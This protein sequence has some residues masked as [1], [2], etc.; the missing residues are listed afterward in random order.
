MHLPFRRLVQKRLARKGLWKIEA[1][2]PRVLLTASV[3]SIS[4]SEA[5]EGNS[6][7]TE[8][9]FTVSRYNDD[10]DY[11]QPE[12]I[13]YFTGLGDDDGSMATPGSVSDPSLGQYDDYVPRSGLAVFEVGETTTLIRIEVHGDELPEADEHFV[14][15]LSPDPYFQTDFS[16]QPIPLNYPHSTAEQITNVSFAPAIKVGL[17]VIL[18]SELDTTSGTPRGIVRVLVNISGDTPSFQ[19]IGVL[20]APSDS[21]EQIVK[22]DSA[23]FDGDGVG[24]VLVANPDGVVI[25]QGLIGQSYSFSAALPLVPVGDLVVTDVVI[26]DINHDGRPDVAIA[27][28]NGKIVFLI[29]SSTENGQ[30]SFANP[31]LLALPTQPVLLRMADLDGNS[32]PDVI[33]VSAPA[34]LGGLTPL[35]I[36]RNIS[37]PGVNDLTFESD[38][39]RVYLNSTWYDSYNVQ[40]NRHIYDIEVSDQ[41]GD[42]RADLV[43]ST[44]DAFGGVYL[45]YET[46]RNDGLQS[47]ALSYVQNRFTYYND[48][49]RG[50]DQT[51]GDANHD[52][53]SDTS[54]VVQSGGGTFLYIRDASSFPSRAMFFLGSLEA[55]AG[56]RVALGDLNLDGA[57][58][59]LVANPEQGLSWLANVSNRTG[60]PGDSQNVGVGTILDD[61]TVDTRP[62]I[63]LSQSRST[64]FT[65]TADNISVIYATLTS[66]Q[67]LSED[68][69]IPILIDPA[70][71]ANDGSTDFADYA[72]SAYQILIPAGYTTGELWLTALPD[73]GGQDDPDE[74]VIIRAESTTSYLVQSTNPLMAIIT[75]PPEIVLLTANNIAQEA[76]PNQFSII[77][78]ASKPVLEDT[79]IEISFV[80]SSSTASLDDLFFVVGQVITIPAGFTTVALTVT[81]IDDAIPESVEHATF[82]VGSVAQ[83]HARTVWNN[84]VTFTF[85][86]NDPPVE[87]PTVPDIRISLSQQTIVAGGNSEQATTKLRAELVS[88]QVLTHDL[89]V[90]ISV[91]A[92]S[93]ASPAAAANPD[94]AASGQVILIAAGNTWGEVT[95]TALSDAA[96]PPEP[97]EAIILRATAT[98]DFSLVTPAPL[99]VTIASIPEIRL[100]L[101][102][103][104]VTEG[105]IDQIQ[106]VAYASRPMIVD[107]DVVVVLISGASTA[108]EADFVAGAGGLIHI[109]AGQTSATFAFTV[110]EDA[111]YEIAETATFGLVSVFQGLA[112]LPSNNLVAATILDND[113]L[114]VVNLRRVLPDGS[115]FTQDVSISETGGTVDVVAVLES[116]QSFSISVPLTSVGSLSRTEYST[117]Y[118][119]QTSTT[120]LPNLIIPAGQLRSPVLRIQSIN[121]VIVETNEVLQ[122]AAVATSAYTVGSRG[123]ISLTVVDDDTP[124]PQ[125]SLQAMSPSIQENGGVSGF[126]VKLNQP[127][128]STVSVNLRFSG[129]ASSSDYSASTTVVIP[130]GETVGVVLVKA[131]DDV[132]RELDETIIA[133]IDSVNG[134]VQSSVAEATMTIRDDDAPVGVSLL[135]ESDVFGERIGEGAISVNLTELTAY[136]VTIRLAFSGSAVL[137]T[138]YTAN[139]AAVTIPAGQGVATLILK[140]IADRFVEGTESVIVLI[141]SIDTAAGGRVVAVPSTFSTAVLELRDDLTP[142][143]TPQLTAKINVDEDQTS[144]VDPTSSAGTFR[145]FDY[146]EQGAAATFTIVSSNPSLIDASGV[147]ISNRVAAS[148]ESNQNNRKFTVTPKPNQ[149]GTATITIRATNRF[150]SAEIS[151]NIIVNPVNDPPTF[152]GGGPDAAFEVGIF[153]DTPVAQNVGT[154]VYDILSGSGNPTR[155]NSLT[156]VDLDPEPNASGIAIVAADRTNGNWQYSTNG[157]ATWGPLTEPFRLAPNGRLDVSYS[158]ALLLAAD[159]A[160]MNRLRFLPK[161]DYSGYFNSNILTIVGWDQTSG[162]SGTYVDLGTTAGQPTRAFGGDSRIRAEVFAT[163][164]FPP[165]LTLPSSTIPLAT[166]PERKLDEP[167]REFTTLDILNAILLSGGSFSD[168]DH[169]LPGLAIGMSRGSSAYGTWEYSTGG[170]WN[171]LP[172]GETY[173][174]IGA[175]GAGGARTKHDPK[176]M[177]LPAGDNFRLRFNSIVSGSSSIAPTNAGVYTLEFPGAAPPAE[178]PELIFRLWDYYIGDTNQ[179]VTIP[180]GHIDQTFGGTISS[181]S[182]HLQLQIMNI[183]DP[184]VIDDTPPITIF[185]GGLFTARGV[186]AREIL[187]AYVRE[188]SG[189]EYDLESFLGAS[190]PDNAGYS[191]GLAVTYLDFNVNWEAQPLNSDTWYSLVH[192]HAT[193]AANPSQ[194]LALGLD[195]RIRVNPIHSY[196]VVRLQ[197]RLHDGGGTLDSLNLTRYDPVPVTPWRLLSTQ[198]FSAIA[199]PFGLSGSAV[200]SDSRETTETIDLDL[201]NLSTQSQHWWERAGLAPELTRFLQTVSYN[202]AAPSLNAL[203]LFDGRSIFINSNALG[204]GWFIDPTPFVDEEYELGP[205]GLLRAIPGGLADGKYDLLSVLAHEQGHLLGLNHPENTDR[206]SVMTDVLAPGVRRRPSPDDLDLL[207]SL[208]SDPESELL[209]AIE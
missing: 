63:T 77:A 195:T 52:G 5:V 200:A 156:M 70:S 62:T 201:E 115:L 125:V 194:F 99:T 175:G 41:D 9:V 110:T 126:Y 58:D 17:S 92:A 44:Q 68:L 56:I 141:G 101:T 178:V 128:S 105:S 14:V 32:L 184:P 67:P 51:V 3:F 174:T 191:I 71:T 104:V 36:V 61:D 50:F 203:G 53:L 47:N 145:V 118:A 117:T 123:P 158:H 137:G 130:A 196:S 60:I 73:P 25:Y 199:I 54:Q 168:E 75:T 89:V 66:G 21:E 172:I 28:K 150:G 74:T 131:I 108:V 78:M 27:D 119:N 144:V 129:S 173:L 147:S 121:D 148:R 84:Y 146:P 88:G 139:F 107:T 209:S 143:L 85:I 37:Q 64:L 116:A 134:P 33:A 72:L 188:Q 142:T 163:N 113:P 82:N 111:L 190:D 192:G 80:S 171:A 49:A 16:V 181:R 31:Q 11:S 87:V 59:Y 96:G 205:D 140:G 177:L 26:A 149:S 153:E 103:S 193:G 155:A 79:Q 207:F 202:L 6:G 23:D 90:P 91:D 161:L 114:P 162:V 48:F 30:I 169:I 159:Q 86:D 42:G 76:G 165:A 20:A 138:D 185:P 69:H 34:T 18:V 170:G 102:R 10:N 154:S 106:L 98:S 29:N 197:F 40:L 95:I 160:G 1:L 167:I 204:V 206:E 2:E 109:P 38:T 151:F 81:L 152:S 100:A 4:N 12:S 8:I 135:V 180:E 183:N 176:F 157:G 55:A 133:T 43:F 186:T 94:Y 122:L 179:L 65:G 164:D 22:V 7:T 120:T 46:W 187:S 136:D 13:P 15:R 112:R 83:G 189:F 97:D 124:P 198:Y 132:L 182:A 57:P 166:I 24:D 35:T 39:S 45:V 127:M 19:S 208:I 93:S